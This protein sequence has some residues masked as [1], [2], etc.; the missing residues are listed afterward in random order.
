MAKDHDPEPLKSL[1]S[2]SSEACVKCYF[3]LH[4]HQP[5]GRAPFP[6][7]KW[8][9]L[10]TAFTSWPSLQ[11]PGN[12]IVLGLLPHNPPPH[13]PKALPL[14][15]S[16]QSGLLV[17]LYFMQAHRQMGNR[18]SNPENGGTDKGRKSSLLS[19]CSKWKLEGLP[20]QS[21]G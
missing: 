1:L 12:T 15:S 16:F 5:C 9:S 13:L 17:I 4:S 11:S 3:L 19:L 6:P 21:S 10:E 14:T 20:W 2:S 7:H 18:A 8:V